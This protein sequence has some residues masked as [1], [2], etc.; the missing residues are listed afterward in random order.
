MPGDIDNYRDL[1]LCGQPLL[2]ARAPVEF[3]KGAFPGAVNLPLMNDD[4]RQKVGLCY[5]EQ[6]QHAAIALGNQL[7]SGST[8]SERVQAWADFA[9]ANPDGCL[10]CF[11]GGLRSQITQQWLKTEAGIDYPRVAGGYKAMRGFLLDTVDQAV[12]QC[13][14]VVIGGMTGTGKTD[15]I[16][17]LNAQQNL[18]LRNGLD[19]EGH[20][21]HRG[22]SFG[23]RATE[24]PSGIDF[25]NC[26]AIDILRKRSK[27]IA[28]FVLED[29]S[30][31]V[32]RCALPLPL[33]QNM[34]ECPMVWLEDSLD[35]RVER[36]LRD[37]VIDLRAEY[38]AVHAEQGD[39]LFEVQ[40]LLSL[41]RLRKRLGGERHQRI[42]A[43]MQA[44]LAEQRCSGAMD[45]HR[46]WIKAL[47][48]E[49]YDP[50]YAYQRE[51]K[52]PRIEFS[53]EQNA[54][55]DYL[56]ERSRRM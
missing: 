20:A 11:R 42:A 1:F 48:L 32:G 45:Q 56:A 12:A 39:G 53:G 30:R 35:G 36:I 51:N 14:L 10:Y 54:V 52:A 16:V 41:D 3:N 28:Q 55:L 8:K 24:Q 4:E 7:V 21:N 34:Q 38:I 37:Y 22:S 50:I 19:L 31:L 43:S 23:K 47:L 29:E 17:E 5:K 33:Y 26:L 27:G 9:R 15:V 40:L 46:E 25:E 6:G 2:D 49:Y 44:A 13:E 18:Q